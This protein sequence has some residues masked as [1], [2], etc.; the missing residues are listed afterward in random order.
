MEVRSGQ[1]GFTLIELVLYIALASIVLGALSSL[2]FS[3]T[4]ARI[5]NT[6]ITEVEEQGQQIMLAITQ[7][8]RN[9]S[10]ITSP[11]I[12]G[13]AASLSIQTYTSTAN[14]TV[15]SLSSGV[16]RVQEGAGAVTALHS[17]RVTVS[18]V[19]FRNVAR[20]N[21]DGIIRVSF[22]VTYANPRN[23]I[24]RQF[25]RSFVNSATV[26]GVYP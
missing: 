2:Y 12:G 17:T 6:S 3:M 24:E 13:T 20:S 4:T 18:N 19:E 26:R 8:V 21:T 9:A 15:F 25:I 7:A 16:F 22:T 14:P 5:K 11:A 23:R 10:S 1:K